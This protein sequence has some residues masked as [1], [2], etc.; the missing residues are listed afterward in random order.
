MFGIFWMLSDEFYD[1]LRSTSFVFWCIIV[2]FENPESQSVVITIYFHKFLSNSGPE[3]DLR[4]KFGANTAFCGQS[5]H[6]LN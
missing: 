4:V 1:P 3:K 6:N 2:K 5:N